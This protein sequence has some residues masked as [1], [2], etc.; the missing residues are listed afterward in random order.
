MN[1]TVIVIVVLAVLLVSAAAGLIVARRKRSTRLQRDFGPE[2]E[3]KA[4]ES[5]SRRKAESQ[6]RERE[7]RHQ[8]LELRPLSDE[9]CHRY[10]EEWNGIQQRFVDEPGRAVEDSDRLARRIMSDR[11]YPVDNFEQRA[12]DVSVDHPHVVQHYRAAHGVAVAHEQGQADMEQLRDAVT[13]YRAFVEALLEDASNGSGSRPEGEG[14]GRE[15]VT[16][17]DTGPS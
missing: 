17:G 4:E 14:S 2:Y 9:A 12:A 7:K 6:L 3:R 11:G 13:S 16:R 1:A 5:G 8:Q 15:E 10:R